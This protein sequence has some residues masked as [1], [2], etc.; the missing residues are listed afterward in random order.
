MQEGI[1]QIKAR[2]E[3]TSAGQMYLQD[4]LKRLRENITEL[5]KDSSKAQGSLCG[6]TKEAA[7]MSAGLHELRGV[8]SGIHTRVGGLRKNSSWLIEGVGALG[9]TLAD[10]RGSLASESV[11]AGSRALRREALPPAFKETYVLQPETT[12]PHMATIGMQRAQN[13][14]P[15]AADFNLTPAGLRGWPPAAA[16]HANGGAS[17]RLR[18]SVSPSSLREGRFRRRSRSPVRRHGWDQGAR[19]RAYPASPADPSSSNPWGPDRSI[20]PPGD[21][22][23]ATSPW[24]NSLLTTPRL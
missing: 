12:D 14:N 5:R 13:Q 4:G 9:G 23:N 11:V 18:R 21:A 22:R 6:L 2:E 15:R 7:Q 19:W 16:V 3:K 24:V 17:P 8:A 20:Y 10:L 1:S